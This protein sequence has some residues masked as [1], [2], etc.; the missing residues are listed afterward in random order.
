MSDYNKAGMD[1]Y[2]KS[3]FAEQLRTRTKQFTVDIITLYQQLPRTTEAQII[4]KQ[5]LRSGSSVGANYR[6]VCRARSKADFYAKVSIVIEE[7]DESL[8]WMEILIETKIIKQEI[9]NSLMDE[10]KQIL[11]ILSAARKTMSASNSN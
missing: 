4:G 2:T 6:A 10:C 3:I 7:A 9:L 11:K 5:L 1:G 8:F